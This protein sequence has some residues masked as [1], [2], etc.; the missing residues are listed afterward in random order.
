MKTKKIIRK[1]FN[2]VTWSL[3]SILF[4]V[5]VFGV[6]DR[7]TGYN[8]SLFGYRVSYITSESMETVHEN[9]VE[10]L[11]ERDDRYYRNDLIF[12]RVIKN[13]DEIKPLDVVLFYSLQH[14]RFVVHRIIKIFPAENASDYY[15]VTRGDANS[16]NDLLVNY[17]QIRGV[18]VKR[19]PKVGDLFGY[20]NSI[21]GLLGFFAV[22]TIYF[23]GC[24]LNEVVEMRH[25]KKKNKAKPPNQNLK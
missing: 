14:N 1:A 11:I 5:S 10:L 23:G 21:Y 20:I 7:L 6:V 13:P 3:I 19:I 18:V 4:V 16:V 12:A 2:I 22:G 25:E 9:N 8:Y 15:F 24:Y 17:L